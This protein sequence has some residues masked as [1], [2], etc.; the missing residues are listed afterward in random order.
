MKTYSLIAIAGLFFATAQLA[1]QELPE[2]LQIEDA[3]RLTLENNFNILIARNNE[4]ISSNNATIGNAG[5]LPTVSINGNY[6]YSEAD[7]RVEFATPGQPPIDANGAGTT[8]YGAGVTLNYT[9]YSGGGQLYTYRKLKKEEER[10]Q[11]QERQAVEQSVLSVLTQY[12]NA[13]SLYDAYQNTLESV[14]ISQ[15]RYTRAKED[16]GFGNFTRLELLN[17]EVDLSNDSTSLFQAKLSYEKARKSLSNAMGIDPSAS[18]DVSGTFDYARD[19][20]VDNLLRKALDQN[21]DY[22]L[23]Q[24]AAESS[25]LDLKL[26]GSDMLPRLDLSGGYSY[27]KAIYDANFLRSSESLG[28]NAGVTLSMDIFGGG[29]KK[30]ARKNARIQKESQEYN[31]QQSENTLKTNVLNSYED[32]NIALQLLELRAK[33]LELAEASYERS[34][35]AFSTGQITGI[36]LREAQLN[37]VNARFNLSTQRIQAKLAELTLLNYAGALVE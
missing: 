3:V 22:L 33:N 17:A 36:E 34:S 4:S 13:V 30:R 31:R 7:T 10:G 32:Y 25:E 35:I 16:Y 12:L 2:T 14:T 28:W 26:S 20:D 24:N 29:V 23:A 8:T 27:N 9:I 37:L 6:N 19:L 21:T 1:A 15:D 11:L 5:Y 18:Y